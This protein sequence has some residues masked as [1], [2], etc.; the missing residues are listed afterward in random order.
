MLRRALPRDP[1]LMTS[2][3]AQRPKDYAELQAAL[4]EHSNQ[5]R[6]YEGGDMTTSDSAGTAN[7]EKDDRMTQITHQLAE[8]TLAF[9]KFEKP[10]AAVDAT[11]FCHSC[12]QQDHF[13]TTCPTNADRTV[14]CH[15]CHRW[16]HRASNCRA[17]V[18][19]TGQATDDGCHY[20]GLDERRRCLLTQS[21]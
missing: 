19:A 7:G 4:L 21:I 5:V 3:V 8:I 14:Q 10:S 2:L 16:G 6:F 1:Q 18:V 13:C 15:K 17:R 12:R 11:A 20:Y 9:K